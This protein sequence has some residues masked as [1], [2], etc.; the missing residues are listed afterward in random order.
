[1]RFLTTIVQSG[2][3]TGIHV[4]DT[5]VDDL[6]AGKRPKVRVTLNDYTYRSSI[7]PW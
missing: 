7:A 3:T 6:G 5:V 1:M 4:P 2:N